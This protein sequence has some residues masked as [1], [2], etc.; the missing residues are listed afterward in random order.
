MVTGPLLLTGSLE[1]EQEFYLGH[2]KS[3][4]PLR[5]LRRDIQLYTVEAMV[6]DLGVEITEFKRKVLRRKG[7]Q[8]C[9]ILL[10]DSIR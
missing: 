3:E 2:G 9:Q 8:V 4:M 1:E 7:D 5:H 10:R 6:K